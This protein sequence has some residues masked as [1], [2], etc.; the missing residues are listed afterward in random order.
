[1]EFFLYLIS[2]IGKRVNSLQLNLTQLEAFVIMYIIF[3]DFRLA[4]W[5]P[6]TGQLNKDHPNIINYV[7]PSRE[8]LS[9]Y[10]PISAPSYNIVAFSS[11]LRPTQQDGLNSSE[12]KLNSD[13]NWARWA[14]FTFSLGSTKGSIFS[15]LYSTWQHWAN[16]I[17]VKLMNVYL[18]ILWWLVCHQ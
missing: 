4:I 13:V 14:N 11:E 15:K 17:K 10:S 6:N 5:F 12:N 7:F 2:C 8:D 16:A 9:G 1:M 18:A 3:E